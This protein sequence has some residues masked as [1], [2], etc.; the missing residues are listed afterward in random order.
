MD[1]ISREMELDAFGQPTFPHEEQA[2]DIEGEYDGEEQSISVLTAASTHHPTVFVSKK[3]MRDPLLPRSFS[4]TCEDPKW[5]AT[6]DREFD[7]IVE[8][9]TWIL[10]PRTVDM[11][12]VPFT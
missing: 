10:I 5:A 6:I 11:H 2:P 9:R 8:R 7:A 1:G 12:P 3:P 4:R